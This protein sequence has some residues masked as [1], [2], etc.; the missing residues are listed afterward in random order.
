MKTMCPQ[1]L[2]CLP[3]DMSMIKL[4]FR[5]L[6]AL[7]IFNLGLSCLLFSTSI[8]TPVKSSENRF[9]HS[10]KKLIGST[11]MHIFKLAYPD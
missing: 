11:N 9:R 1:V 7:F 6:F 8:Q 10:I 5:N 3:T 4:Y 2:K